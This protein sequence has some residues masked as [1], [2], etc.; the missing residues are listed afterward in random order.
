M[1]EKIFYR[2]QN[3]IAVFKYYTHE[4]FKIMHNKY[5]FIY[6]YIQLYMCVCLL[7]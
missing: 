5:D 2:K 6:L 7:K 3:S 4:I 1:K